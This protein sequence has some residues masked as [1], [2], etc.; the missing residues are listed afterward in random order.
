M[1]SPL[2]VRTFW[3]QVAPLL[4]RLDAIPPVHDGRRG[5][6]RKRPKKAHGD[7]GYD[8]KGIPRIALRGIESR[9]KATPSLLQQGRKTHAWLPGQY[10]P[11]PIYQPEVQVSDSW[12]QCH[13][14]SQRSPVAPPVRRPGSAG[15]A[16]AC[17]AL[18]LWRGLFSAP[19]TL[20]SR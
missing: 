13:T 7:K 11:T 14:T 2:G 3:K 6:P 19:P 20:R 16:G 8:F 1:R 10:P 12:R 5:R 4:P 9:L 15:E 17:R 18:M